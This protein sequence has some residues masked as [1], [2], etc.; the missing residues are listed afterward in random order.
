MPPIFKGTSFQLN[1]VLPG[2]VDV[3]WLQR[4]ASEPR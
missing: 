4:H 2:D 1:V 3:D